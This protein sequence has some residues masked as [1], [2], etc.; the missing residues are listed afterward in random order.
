MSKDDNYE[1]EPEED[2]ILSNFVAKKY[3]HTNFQSNVGE[4]SKRT[5]LENECH[6]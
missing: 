6:G 3:I 2:E 5:R 4:F 1:F